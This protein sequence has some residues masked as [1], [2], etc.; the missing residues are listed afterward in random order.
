MRVKTIKDFHLISLTVEKMTPDEK[1]NYFWPQKQNQRVPV[2]SADCYVKYWRTA[3][4]GILA[5]FR[6]AYG[7]QWFFPHMPN[8]YS[9]QYILKNEI[10]SN[11]N[12]I[13][14]LI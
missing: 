11:L 3:H 14:Y 13:N 6:I 8:I 2:E 4:F 10:K 1:Y 5:G 9:E 7:N 12:I